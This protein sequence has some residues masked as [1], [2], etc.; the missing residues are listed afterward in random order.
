MSEPPAKPPVPPPSTGSGFGDKDDNVIERRSLRDYY[1]ILR[2][3]I[4]IALPLALLVS[5]GLGYYQSRD[6]PM[7][8]AKATMQFEKPERVVTTQGVTDPSITSEID[9]N[10]HIQVLRSD[11]LRAKVVASL[12]PEEIKILQRPFLKD[13]APGAAPP[14]PA[15]LL[16][17]VSVEA[18]RNSFLIVITV[19]H[20]DPVLSLIHI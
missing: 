18:V 11:N 3:R 6:T 9:L 20:Q 16:G 14:S 2:E 13:L 19:N 12:T 15:G 17:N 1:I 7:Y 8:E 10:T 5:I 4:W